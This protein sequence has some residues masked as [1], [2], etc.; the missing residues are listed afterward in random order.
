MK[1]ISKISVKKVYNLN[2]K[3]EA[4]R[5]KRNII[6][7]QELKIKEKTFDDFQL[8]YNKNDIEELIRKYHIKY[9]Q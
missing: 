5:I 1:K 4:L 7:N 9:S 3:I 8:A 6:I 2:N